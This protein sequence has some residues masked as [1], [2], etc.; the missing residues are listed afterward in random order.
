LRETARQAYRYWHFTSHVVASGDRPEASFIALSM[1]P[2]RA[3]MEKLKIADILDLPVRAEM[4]MLNGCDSGLGK[5]LPGAGVIGLARAFLAAGSRS[6]CATRWKIPDEGGAL[7]TALYR[8][9]AEGSLDRAEALQQAQLEMLRAG[10]W[11]SEPR[12]WAAYFLLGSC[13]G[14][15]PAAHARGGQWMRR[16]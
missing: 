13:H 11:R 14:M 12:Y 3:P 10:D 1:P 16:P 5:N 9:L 7:V 8:R 15:A 6:V 4:V 2:S